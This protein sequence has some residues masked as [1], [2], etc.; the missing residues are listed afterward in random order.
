MQD[1]LRVGLAR[2]ISWVNRGAIPRSLRQCDVLI[3]PELVDGGYA[4]LARGKGRHTAGDSLLRAFAALTRTG[5]PLCIAGSILLNRPRRKATNTSLIFHRGRC[6]CRYEKIHLFVG[7]KPYFAPGR[8]IAMF[9]LPVRRR[10]LRSGVILCYDLR[11]P[12]LVR[13]MALRGMRI[14]FVPAR[15]PSVRDLAWRS[16]LRARAIENQIF[17]VGCNG[18]GREG[19]PSYVFD[20]MGKELL[21][22]K[23]KRPR[24]I[25]TVDL[26]LHRLEEARRMHNNLQD[27]VVLRSATIPRVLPKG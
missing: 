11:F 24:R 26:P 15:W 17:V 9:S 8:T 20:P 10:R 19:G 6:V 16:L 3:F 13:A 22:T 25:R 21:S 12:E 4:A 23:G 2:D 27:A 5:V 18:P 14:L 7:D 1:T